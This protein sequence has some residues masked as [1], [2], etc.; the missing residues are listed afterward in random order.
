MSHE[1]TR[2][3]ARVTLC[4]TA[5]L[6]AASCAADDGPTAET[7]AHL[8]LTDWSPG[9]DAMQ[10]LLQGTLAVRDGCVVVEAPAGPFTVPALPRS[11]VSWDDARSVLTYAGREYA[12]GDPI[13]AGGGGVGGDAGGGEAIAEIESPAA[14]ADLANGAYFSV[15]VDSLG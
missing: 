6:L 7:K 11:L 3:I 10:A 15:Q 9:D 13:S 8:A 4:A 5:L 1:P 2:H 14:C 12:V